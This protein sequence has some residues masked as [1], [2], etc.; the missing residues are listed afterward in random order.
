MGEHLGNEKHDA[1]G[2]GNSWNGTRVK[3]LLTGSAGPVQV[4]VPRDC[5]GRLDPVI[6]AKHRRRLRGMDTIALSLFAKSLTAG[7]ISAHFVEIYRV[8]IAKDRV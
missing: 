7:E 4:T 5:N 6:V 1:A 8:S 2:C 3:T